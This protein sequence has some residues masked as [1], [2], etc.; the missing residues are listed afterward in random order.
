MLLLCFRYLYLVC[1]LAGLWVTFV[2]YRH[3][4]WVC[5]ELRRRRINGIRQF[6]AMALSDAERLRFYVQL[7]LLVPALVGLQ[8]PT[9]LLSGLPGR[10]KLLLIGSLLAQTLIAVLMAV[11]AANLRSARLEILNVAEHEA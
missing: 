3:A 5:T 11:K 8:I 7:L 10:Y 2:E 9:G 6:V 4:R 1:V